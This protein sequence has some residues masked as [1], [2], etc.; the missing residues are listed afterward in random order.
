MEHDPEDWVGLNEALEHVMKATGKTK[1]QA[2]SAI[3]AAMKSGVLRVRGVPEGPSS[4]SGG[5]ISDLSGPSQRQEGKGR[6]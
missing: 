1:R 6:P 2:K 4:G 3:V 5:G